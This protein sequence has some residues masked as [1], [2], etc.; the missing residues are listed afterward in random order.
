MKLRRGEVREDGK[1]FMRY[2]R[3]KE[4]WINPLDFE[5]QTLKIQTYNKKYE[6]KKPVENIE[7]SRSKKIARQL[8]ISRKQTISPEG[9][10]K[11]VLSLH[12]RGKDIVTISLRMGIP[13][14]TI[15]KIINNK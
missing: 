12:N 5:I 10:A 1:I 2:R 11:E 8:L 7:R 15:T 4:V 6:S 9:R 14:S 13:I 3:D